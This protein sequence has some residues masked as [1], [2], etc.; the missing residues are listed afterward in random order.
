[1]FYRYPNKDDEE[2]SFSMVPIYSD[3]ETDPG[4]S[5]EGEKDETH[6]SA[7]LAQSFSPFN[8][9]AISGYPHPVLDRN[10]W[11]YYLLRFRGSEHDDPGKHL[12]NFHRCMIEHDFVHKY[13]LIKMFKFYLEGDAPEWCKSLHAASIHSLKDFH[14][15][16]NAYYVKSYLSHLILGHCC[17]KFAFYI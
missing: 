9:S 17:K 4:E 8:F 13:V 7:I 5:H 6:L 16:F 2:K 1:L 14:N 12:F 11:D 15:V 10:E 3:C